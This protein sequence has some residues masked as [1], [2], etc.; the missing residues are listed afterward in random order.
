MYLPLGL[1]KL[2]S[3]QLRMR[4]PTFA[5][6]LTRPGSKFPPSFNKKPSGSP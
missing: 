3:L 5:A 4:F 1:A 2:R 6:A